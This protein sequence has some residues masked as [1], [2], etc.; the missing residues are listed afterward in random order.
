MNPL[1]SLADHGQAV[2]LDF[3]SR[4]FIAKGGLKK[5]VDDDGLRGVTS[6]PSIFEQAIGHSDEYDNAIGRMLKAQDRGVGEIFEQLAIED[7]KHAT[8]V[9]RPVYDATG[10]ADGYV[11][12]EVSPYLAQDTEAT[13]A[14]A[15]HLW[16]EI[17]RKNLMIKVPATQE[18]LPAVRDLIA[19]G[20]N[21]NITLLFAQA[22]YEQVVEA[23]LSGLEALAAKDGDVSKIASVA[24]FFV[25]R[26]DTAV[27]KLLDDKIAAANDPDEKD[28]SRRAQG[29]NRHRQR[30]ACL[31]ALQAAVRGRA[32][33]KA[34]GQRRA[35]AAV[36]VGLNRHQEQGL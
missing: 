20:I 36:A 5:L 6:N 33:E 17:G 19:S 29:Q 25:S 18:G 11:S 32:L 34:R 23:Y 30:Q 31:P 7:I 24:S 14:E 1:Q 21:V 8:D 3:L 10:G 27:D 12:I 9:L 4:G 15:K 13:I 35:A 22:V 26:I 2:W 28:A 16:Q